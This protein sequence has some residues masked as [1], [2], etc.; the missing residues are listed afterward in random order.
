MGVDLDGKGNFSGKSD[1]VGK[2]DSNVQAE[3]DGKSDSDDEFT[4]AYPTQCTAS[5]QVGRSHQGTV[6]A[7]Y[8]RDHP[9]GLVTDPQRCAK[10]CAANIECTYYSVSRQASKG[11]VLKANKRG[12]A[13]SGAHFLGH[14]VC[15]HDLPTI[16]TQIGVRQGYSGFRNGKLGTFKNIRS[17]GGCAQ[18]CQETTRCA[19]W[20]V[21]N[22]LGCVLNTAKKGKLKTGKKGLMYHGE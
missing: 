14:G 10:L 15:S 1:S 3:S 5:R 2:G 8:N 16:C 7:K 21:H 19:Y 22:R 18:K 20:L 4:T 12:K 6:I 9:D 11:C 13:V 17:A